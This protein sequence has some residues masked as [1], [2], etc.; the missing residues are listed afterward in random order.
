[1]AIE[2]PGYVVDV[3]Y[4]LELP[5]P[6]VDEDEL[7]GWASD[8]R[9]FGTEFTG[10]S[11][12]ARRVT[13]GLAASSSSDALHTI[14][15]AWQRWDGLFAALAPA[16]GI[17]ADALDVAADEV[18]AQKLIVI[19]QAIQLAAEL[20]ATTV[21]A[22]FTFGADEV[23]A[24]AEIL[25]T[26]EIVQGCLRVLENEII[27]RVAGYAAGILSD[28]V[29]ATLTRDLFGGLNLAGTGDVLRADYEAITGV[30]RQV[31]EVGDEADESSRSTWSS[32][33]SRQIE[34]PAAGGGWPVTAVLKQLLERMAELVF[35]QLPRLFL[36]LLRDTW[37]Y[38]SHVVAAFKETDEALAR[39]AERE[40]SALQETATGAAIGASEHFTGDVETGGIGGGDGGGTGAGSGVSL[41]DDDDDG[42]GD[43]EDAGA[44]GAVDLNGESLTGHSATF[45]YTDSLD[46]KKTFFVEYPDLEGEVV[47]HHAV[48]QQT[49][50]RY[51]GTVSPGEMHSLENLRGIPKGEVN[52]RVHLSELRKEW[53]RFYRDTPSPS[54]QDLLDHATKLDKKYGSEFNPP[55]K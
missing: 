54:K 17:F 28:D 31:Q 40:G 47:V 37:E 3:F 20:A 24:P 41:G 25:G 48:E 43:E 38:L 36:G 10:H 27:G 42:D 5:W 14:A 19:E 7:R 12:R 6:N 44:A 23:A 33:E 18:V 8:L 55:I 22:F 45:G 39:D 1:M 21:G 50:L 52:N 26:R 13:E 11:A 53:N 32:A 16:T 49:L 2:L 15:S 29:S 4:F 30:S 51:P 34:T 9:R 46:Y 35:S